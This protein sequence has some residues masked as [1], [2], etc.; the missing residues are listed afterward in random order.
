M[1]EQST[2]EIQDIVLITDLAENSWGS[3][4]HAALGH[5]I[6]FMDPDTK[7]KP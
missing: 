5:V 7:A 2:L 3:N 4:P 1:A 6:G